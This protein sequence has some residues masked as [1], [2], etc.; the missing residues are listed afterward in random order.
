V[1]AASTFGSLV[2]CQFDGDGIFKILTGGSQPQGFN[3]CTSDPP[4]GTERRYRAANRVSGETG[5]TQYQRPFGLEIGNEIDPISGLLVWNTAGL[6]DGGAYSY[7]VVA[8]LID[9]GTQELITSTPID[10]EFV[11]ENVTTTGDPTFNPPGG[12]P[13]TTLQVNQ[14]YAFSVEVSDPH[15]ENPGNRVHVVASALPPGASYPSH[16]GYGCGGPVGQACNN[17]ASTT[18]YFSW[19]PTNAEAGL[20]TL[21]LDAYGY[22]GDKP[23]P[24]SQASYMFLVN[25]PPDC[26]NATASIPAGPND[27][28]FYPVTITG[29]T[30][31]DGDSFTVEVDTTGGNGIRQDEPVE[32][33]CPDG[34]VKP[35]VLTAMVRRETVV[36][37]G[38]G[39]VYTIKIIVRDTN[40]GVCNGVV[41]VCV[42]RTGFGGCT[43]EGPVYRSLECAFSSMITMD[44]AGIKASVTELGMRAAGA[45]PGTSTL[46]Y[47][48]PADGDV[49]LKVY[50]IAGRELAT[51]ESSH[52]T[53]GIH[54]VDWNTAG[55]PKGVYFYRLVAGGRM[56]SKTIPLVR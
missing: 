7:M 12:G 30:D 49:S 2:S 33:N 9:S 56:I 15:A 11:V 50:D 39:R 55:V 35:G 5:S 22:L 21:T 42:P 16:N 29:I 34:V 24:N 54:R 44:A 31:P 32:A 13:T 43:D 14:P 41:T 6:E 27:H 38:N 47:S 25:R 37:E 17:P 18:G 51:L 48:L 28:L 20:H 1:D 19:T 26:S 8:E 53:A 36:N 40:G 4:P 3:F 10:V 52:R 23:G 45:R 46:E